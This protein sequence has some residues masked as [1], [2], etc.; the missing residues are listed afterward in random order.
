MPLAGQL[1]RAE[2]RLIVG[3]V[4]HPPQP[5]ARGGAS[6]AP[7][8]QP[9]VGRYFSSEAADQFRMAG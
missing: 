2:G 6:E 7:W 3:Q 1:T 4:L 8:R 5:F 9:K